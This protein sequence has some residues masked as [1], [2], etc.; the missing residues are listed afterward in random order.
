[1]TDYEGFFLLC[2]MLPL[3]HEAGGIHNI[4]INVSGFEILSH[5]WMAGAHLEAPHVTRT[6][7]DP[8]IANRFCELMPYN[9]CFPINKH[10]L[11]SDQGS[12]WCP[13]CREE[14]WDMH[15]VGS[16][17]KNTKTFKNKM[18]VSV[19]IS[20]VTWP[21]ANGRSVERSNIN[22]NTG[23]TIP[24]KSSGSFIIEG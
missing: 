16:H 4:G 21:S 7:M 8:R 6:R 15:N 10:L 17:I 18:M 12:N 1:M 2:A 20:T 3:T 19:L 23:T 9:I 24:R 14:H 22:T 5:G 11:K 13:V